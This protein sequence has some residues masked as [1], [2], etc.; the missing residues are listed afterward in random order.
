MTAALRLLA[1]ALVAAAGLLGGA[2]PAHATPGKSALTPTVNC[3][4]SGDQL[5][6]E[7]YGGFAVKGAGP[8]T[9]Y[10]L[11]GYV[12]AGDAMT[13]N[14][15]GENTLS[16]LQGTLPTEF[17]AGTQ[18]GK[19]VAVLTSADSE[20]SWKLGMKTVAISMKSAPAC[21]DDEMPTEG[22]GLG[23]P[24]ALL[25]SVPIGLAALLFAK[26]RRTR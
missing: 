16:G 4:A 15:G 9:R 11:L 14:S 20:G 21:H 25:L 5:T 13:L 3:I 23:A 1:A 10:A 19:G 8:D 7:G 18:Y 12:N 17:A 6:A 22:N 2:G 26:R 24:I